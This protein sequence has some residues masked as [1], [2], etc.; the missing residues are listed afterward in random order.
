VHAG[1]CAQLLT[2]PS[3]CSRS[4]MA[5]EAHLQHTHTHTHHAQ[6]NTF[7]NINAHTHTHA[8]THTYTHCLQVVVIGGGDTGTDCIGTSV[9]HGATSVVNLELMAKP[10]ASR[11][12]GNAWPQWPRIFRVDYGACV[13]CGR[14]LVCVRV[15]VRLCGCCG[16]VDPFLDGPTHSEAQPTL[17]PATG[18]DS[19]G[20]HCLLLLCWV[21][22]VGCGCGCGVCSCVCVFVHLC[23]FVLCLYMSLSHAGTAVPWQGPLQ[24][25]HHGFAQI[26][27]EL[28]QLCGALSQ[29]CGFDVLLVVRDT[30]Y[31]QTEQH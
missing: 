23:V 16:M 5:L 6:A 27:N 24:R 29:L 30:C 19:H 7:T 1:A 22:G 21:L 14:C 9:R 15:C 12:P 2:L 13:C 17:R 18:W 28:R 25:Q 20:V 8:H 26:S 3:L 11:A 4:S 31:A 10:P